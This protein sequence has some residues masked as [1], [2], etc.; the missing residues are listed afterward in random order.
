MN[1]PF[2]STRE[3]TIL[4]LSDLDEVTDY[5]VSNTEG[6]RRLL[7]S[8]IAEASVPGAHS[9]ARW[10]EP[11]H[12]DSLEWFA[13]AADLCRAMTWLRESSGR[14]GLR[15]IREILET[16]ARNL[17]ADEDTWTYLGFKGGSEPGVLNV[18]AILRRNDGR[19]F[20]VSVGLN[21]PNRSVDGR[22]AQSAL[23]TA[24]DLLAAN[25]A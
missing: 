8:E 25:G 24:L 5:L 4:K 10:S 23:T 9:L 20:F 21:D 17:G 2:L 12:I 14:P 11:K 16:D 18:T 7:S 6:R 22:S 13:S 15:P 19:W 1:V 3:L